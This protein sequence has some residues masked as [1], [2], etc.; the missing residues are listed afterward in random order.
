[1]ELTT[2]TWEQAFEHT[3]LSLQDV[4]STL[5]LQ[6]DDLVNCFTTLAQI[7]ASFPQLIEHVIGKTLP[8]NLI[9]SFRDARNWRAF[10]NPKDLAIAISLE[11]SELLE[12]FQWSGSDTTVAA[13][14]HDMEEELAD[15]L[16]YAVQFADAIGSEM[17]TII[18][19]K[20]RKNGEK[21]PEPHQTEN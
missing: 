13:K 8:V 1:M 16:I 9:R 12:C 15:I 4:A 20:L 18:E 11:A 3:K 7:N 14:K 21:Y 6:E 17:K 5:N 10:H 19:Q 2:Q